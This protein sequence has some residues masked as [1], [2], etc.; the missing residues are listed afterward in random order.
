MEH[1]PR[2]TKIFN[3]YRLLFAINVH[4]PITFDSLFQIFNE[5]ITTDETHEILYELITENRVAEDA[6]SYRI[7]RKGTESI[8]PGRGRALRDVQRMEFLVKSNREG[9]HRGR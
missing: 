7:T 1:D 3:K 4:Q 5:R 6:E 2:L 8:I 9:E